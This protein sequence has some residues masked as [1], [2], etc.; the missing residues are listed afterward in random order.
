MYL[1]STNK[2]RLARETGLPVPSSLEELLDRRTVDTACFPPT[3]RL[4]CSPFSDEVSEEGAICLH[5]WASVRPKLLPPDKKLPAPTKSPLLIKPSLC[6][7]RPLECESDGLVADGISQES[8]AKCTF[9]SLEAGC[10][11]EPG[12]KISFESFAP[13]SQDKQLSDSDISPKFRTTHKTPEC[14]TQSKLLVRGPAKH[15]RPLVNYCLRRDAVQLRMRTDLSQLAGQLRSSKPRGRGPRQTSP[16]HSTFHISIELSSL[17][18]LAQQSAESRPELMLNSSQSR[19]RPLEPGDQPS[20]F[21]TDGAPLHQR[22]AISVKTI[23]R[24][25]RQQPMRTVL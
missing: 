10:S 8:T 7:T 23:P 9:Q 17:D 12:I 5:G 21:K 19:F 3:S 6:Y 15:S 1:M 11:I 18:E 16:A 22:L 24:S 4:N 20:S 13:R 25:H 2:G 14:P